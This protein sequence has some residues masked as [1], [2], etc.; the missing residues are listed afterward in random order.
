MP[1]KWLPTRPSVL[2]TL[3]VSVAKYQVKAT[4]GR[5]L[6]FSS[7]SEDTVHQDREVVPSGAWDG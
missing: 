3:L 4:Q 2:V 7:L 5:K 6:Y 1:D